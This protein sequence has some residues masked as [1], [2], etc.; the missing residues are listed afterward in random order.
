MIKMMV[1]CFWQA[2]TKEQY[3]F[4]NTFPFLFFQKLKQKALQNKAEE[5]KSLNEV[6]ENYGH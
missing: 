6:L 1:A 3:S 4:H 5:L 2:Y